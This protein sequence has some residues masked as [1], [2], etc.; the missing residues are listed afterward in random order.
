M[1]KAGKLLLAGDIGGTKTVIGIFRS[2]DGCLEKEREAVYKNGAFSS[3]IGVIS[4]FLKDGEASRISSA[5]FGIACPVDR[6]RCRMT[7]LDW[8][9][10]G[11]EIKSALGVKKVALINDLV[12][13]AWGLERLPS[14]SIYTINE[15]EAKTGNAVLIAAGTGLGEAMLVWN[16]SEHIPSGSEGG[17]CDFAPTNDVEIELLRYLER[18]YGRVSC[19]RILSGAGLEGIYNFLNHK[20][21]LK[22][23]DALTERFIADGAASVISDEALNAGDATCVEALNVFASIYGSEAGN[24]AL[25]GMAVAG[26]YVGGGIAPKVLSVIKGGGFMK[27][28]ADKGRF[29]EM[30]LRMPVRVILDEKTALLGA[31]FYASR[32]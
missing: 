29:K 1:S 16:G 8:T 27:A 30:M 22:T 17:H 10:D 13:T 18:Q 5:A 12:A 24:L 15:G 32:L 31:A 7:N 20:N 2:V 3:V 23:G 11:E 4:A 19:E 28:F 9:V 26:V 6:N 14:E 21:G 25:K